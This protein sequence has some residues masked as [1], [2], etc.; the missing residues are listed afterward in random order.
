MSK[1]QQQLLLSLFSCSFMSNS[2]QPPG[3]QHARLPCPS[4]LPG[5]CSNSC[6][7]SWWCSPIILNSVIPFSPY[8]LSFLTSGS[9]PI[10][11]LF[12]SGSQSIG[13]SASASVLPMNIQ[14]WFP[15]GLTGLISLLSKRLSRL[16][17]WWL[18]FLCIFQ[19]LYEKHDELKSVVLSHRGKLENLILN[20]SLWPN[21]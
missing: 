19:S 15:L 17:Q 12:S 21:H 16:Q 2:L 18:D 13:A 7:L 6:P 9:F 4:P 11:R 5:A 1:W 10:S 20:P 3:L 14:G 8:L